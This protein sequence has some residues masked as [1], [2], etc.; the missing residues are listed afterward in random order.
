MSLIFIA[1][2]CTW[3]LNFIGNTLGID[4]LSKYKTTMNNEYIFILYII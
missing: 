2:H 4:V 1:N 3:H